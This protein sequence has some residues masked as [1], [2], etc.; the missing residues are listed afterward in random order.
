MTPYNVTYN[1]AAHSATGTAKGINGV[2]PSSDLVL[3]TTH[4]N[5]GVY[6]DSWT[7]TDPNYVSQS[8]TVTDVINK[9]NAVI[10]IQP[11]IVIYNGAVHNATVTATGVNGA[12]NGLSINSAHV[13][14]GTYT[15]SWSFTD[16]TG[17]YNNASG[18][19]ADNIAKANATIAVSGYNVLYDGTN[20]S[21]TGAAY[22]VNGA[23]L[24]GLNLA[25]TV[26]SN[27][28]THSDTWTFN[29]ANYNYAQGTVVD[30]ITLPRVSVVSVAPVWTEVL[31]R[32]QKVGKVEKPIYK[33]VEV[34]QIVFSGNVTTA[35]SLNDYALECTPL[36]G[37]APYHPVALSQ[38][39][40]VDPNVV[41]LTT[42]KPLQL[43][44]MQVLTVMTPDVIGRSLIGRIKAS[45]NQFGTWLS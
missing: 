44:P 23:P 19:F 25:G 31:V 7:F 42:A 2:L 35:Q 40:L 10:G 14:A 13:N 27:V 37:K 29:S 21:A 5:V 39:K 8:G 20:H 45:F 34:I 41:Q 17:N 30:I 43:H 3:S 9:T 1:V 33:K 15:D 32:Y 38:V 24:A 16:S 28:G 36:C 11:Y 22:G 12:L 6:S 26:H 4:T 18:Q